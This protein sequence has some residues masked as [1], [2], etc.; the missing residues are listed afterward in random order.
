MLT[1]RRQTLRRAAAPTL[2]SRSQSPRAGRQRAKP[3]GDECG[4]RRALCPEST[5]DHAHISPRRSR[6]GCRGRGDLRETLLAS[7]ERVSRSGAGVERD[8][9]I[10][11]KRAT[12]RKRSAYRGRWHRRLGRARPNTALLPRAGRPGFRRLRDR[13]RRDAVYGRVPGWRPDVAARHLALVLRDG[14]G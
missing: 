5:E 2:S 8:R 4:T 14:C 13:T 6:L 3:A 7:S 1:T 11:S 10:H 9:R 12:F